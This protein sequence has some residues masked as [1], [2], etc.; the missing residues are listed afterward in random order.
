LTENM[1]VS[2]DG[3]P[4]VQPTDNANYTDLSDTGDNLE[5][6]T[7]AE[8]ITEPTEQPTTTQPIATNA[9]TTTKPTEQSTATQPIATQPDPQP[10]EEPIE[11]KPIGFNEDTATSEEYIY[12]PLDTDLVN[13]D[14]EETE[15]V[16][17]EATPIN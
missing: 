11:T 16:Y 10:I 8:T 17:I 7:N 6:P 4:I 1:T 14:E 15:Y 5:I 9:V 3:T 2:E 13:L 12:V